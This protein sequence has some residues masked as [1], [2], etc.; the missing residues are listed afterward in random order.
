MFT[1][2]IYGYISVSYLQAAPLRLQTVAHLGRG[3]KVL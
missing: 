3:D 1:Y 2:G